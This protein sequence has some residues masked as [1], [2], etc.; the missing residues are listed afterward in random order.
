MAGSGGKSIVDIQ[1]EESVQAKRR[2]AQEAVLEAERTAAL[3][4]ARSQG[5]GGWGKSVF[6]PN[7]PSGKAWHA[8]SP[9][10]LP[11]DVM[12]SLDESLPQ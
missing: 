8:H 7:A 4:A 2:A 9:R 6:R 3:T 5:S 11:L 12:V 10:S 1:K